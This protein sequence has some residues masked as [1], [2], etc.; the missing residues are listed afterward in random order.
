MRARHL[1]ALMCSG[2]ASMVSMSTAAPA[3]ASVQIFTNYADWAAAAPGN[4]Q[5]LDFVFG[6]LTGLSTQYSQFGVTF[7]PG[8]AIAGGIEFASD[9]WGFI[10]TWEANGVVPAS[11]SV[12]QYAFAMDFIDATK[13]TF[14]L[15]DTVVYESNTYFTLS[16]PK[17]RGFLL[18]SP[19]D[20]VLITTGG[21]GPHVGI[22]NLYVGTPIPAPSAVAVFALGL[23]RSR[24]RC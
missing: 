24:R 13:L 11:F 7:D 22:D 12:P 4:D 20:H 21:L 17:F 9:G 3:V 23:R 15:G 8:T 18:D 6:G 1:N 16:P 5:K 19:F 14:L 10:S 2:A